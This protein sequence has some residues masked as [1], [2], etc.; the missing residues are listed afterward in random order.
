MYKWWVRLSRQATRSEVNLTYEKI[1]RWGA[2]A[3]DTGSLTDMDYGFISNR[4]PTRLMNKL[5]IDEV[6]T[7]WGFLSKTKLAKPRRNPT[8]IPSDKAKTFEELKKRKF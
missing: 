3:V 2:K 8:H 1:L 4:N 7:N 6:V 5:K